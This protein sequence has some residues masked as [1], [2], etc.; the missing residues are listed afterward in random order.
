MPNPPRPP[1][2][3]LLKFGKP[4]SPGFGIRRDY[5][6]S[7]LLP[8]SRLP[9]LLEIVNPEGAG[10]AARGMGAPM[11][12]GASKGDLARPMERGV[13]AIASM[14]RKTV[15]RLMIMPKEE[16]GFDP[17][18]LLANADA[19][20]LDSEMQSRIRSTWFVA[21]LTFESYDPM[22]APA[23]DLFL[24]LAARL[25]SLT[26]GVV[27]DPVSMR[28]EL[29]E[30]LAARRPGIDVSRLVAVHR[31]TTPQGLTAFTLG[32]QKFDLPE[33][34]LLGFAEESAARAE[35]LVM[36]LARAALDGKPLE[37]G[38]SYGTGASA[39]TLAECGFDRARW[40]GIRCLELVPPRGRTVDQALA[41]IAPQVH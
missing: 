21:Q 32:L 3:E 11:A 34:E 31:R 28:Y 40:E 30:W 19:L 8:A 20:G 15:V 4:K 29:P 35:A 24:D 7:V 6:L 37:V 36:A 13:Y 25:G 17:E 18:P 10:G 1:L 23:L 9:A 38:R 27:A 39:F 41:D 12:S 2:R 5:Y 22:V 14:D 26:G 33:I 16:A